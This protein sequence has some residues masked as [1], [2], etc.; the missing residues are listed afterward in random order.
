MVEIHSLTPNET[1]NA[2]PHT[3]S[4]ST[5]LIEQVPCTIRHGASNIPPRTPSHVHSH[6]TDNPTNAFLRRCS[7]MRRP[8]PITVKSNKANE[9]NARVHR[10]VFCQLTHAPL[11]APFL[12]GEAAQ[13]IKV[14]SNHASIQTSLTSSLAALS[15]GGSRRKSF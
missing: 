8:W 2:A 13:C 4:V 15:E 3:T 14:I 5:K 7:C 1:G 11:G 9:A 6:C 10:V 12:H